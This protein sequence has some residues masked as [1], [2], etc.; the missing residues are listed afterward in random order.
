MNGEGPYVSEIQALRSS[1]AAVAY[2]DYG[3]AG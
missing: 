2:E 3:L 1:L